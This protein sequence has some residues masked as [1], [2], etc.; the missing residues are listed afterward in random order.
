[1]R[2][3][4]PHHTTRDDA[5]KKVDAKIEHLMGRFGHHAD[6]SE[7]EWKGDTLHFHIKAKGMSAKA[8]LEVTDS[9][10]ILDAKLP[11]MA[12]PFEGRIRS[13]LQEEA[14]SMFKPA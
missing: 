4:L 2:I 13:T 6:H 11:F 8:T 14:E 7:H 9:D 10:V 3:E 5:R 1:M 12:L